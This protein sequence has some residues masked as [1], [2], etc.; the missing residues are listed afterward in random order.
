M[1]HKHIQEGKALWLVLLLLMVAAGVV[2]YFFFVEREEIPD[3]AA[4]PLIPVKVER[5]EAE[6]QPQP[7]TEEE[8]A[9]PPASVEEEVVEEAV[10]LPEL[11]E[12][13]EEALAAA[14]AWIADDEK[15]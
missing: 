6:P 15:E 5:E 2:Y 7:V 3:L 9:P 13:D 11:A 1:T 4:P 12:S 10:P 14:E 8:V